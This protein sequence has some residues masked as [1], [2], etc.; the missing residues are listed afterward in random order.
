VALGL[1][2]V[3]TA[4]VAGPSLVPRA[5]HSLSRCKHRATLLLPPRCMRCQGLASQ[6]PR[7]RRR[8]RRSWLLSMQLAPPP[9]ARVK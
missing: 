2:L 7:R 1:V 8:Q 6:G 9:L 4:V 3:P 5:S